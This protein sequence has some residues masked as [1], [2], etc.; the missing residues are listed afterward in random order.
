[1]VEL[2]GMKNYGSIAIGVNQYQFF[3]PLSFAQQDA[4]ALNNFLIELGGF[5]APKCQLLTESSPPNVYVAEGIGNRSTY[6]NRENI[7]QALLA[8]CEQLAAGD[9]FWFFFSGYGVSWQ[10][11]DYLMPIEGNPDDVGNT[12]I[13]TREILESLKAASGSDRA[14]V[15]LDVNRA[16]GT[17][18]NARI[19]PATE[20]IARQ[21]EI[22]TIFSCQH[23]QFSREVAGLERGFFTAALLEGLRQGCHTLEQ[24]DAHLR[25]RLPEISEQYFRP[26]QDPLLVIYPPAKIQGVLWPLEAPAD[27]NT[28]DTEHATDEAL[29]LPPRTLPKEA[30]VEG[31]PGRASVANLEELNGDK[32][33]NNSFSTATA[34]LGAKQRPPATTNGASLSP[35]APSPTVATDKDEAPTKREEKFSLA[36]VALIL[37]CGI[38]LAKLAAFIDQQPAQQQAST[39]ET[40]ADRMEKTSPLPGII[41][42]ANSINGAGDSEPGSRGDSETGRLGDGETGSRGDSETGRLGDSETG[43]NTATGQPSNTATG[44]PSNTATAQPSNTATAQPSNTVTAQPSN[45]ATGQPSNTATG[46]PSNT[47]TA[48]PSNTATGQPSN[49]ATGQPSN[50]ATGQPSNTATGQPSN[51][52]TGTASGSTQVNNATGNLPMAPLKSSQASAFVNAI[53]RSRQ[54]K[55]SDRLYPEAQQNIDR[56]SQVIL[57]I[58]YARAEE[59]NFGNAIAAAKMVPFDRAQLRAKAEQQIATWQPQYQL[60]QENTKL[61]KDA[62]ALIRPGVLTTYSQ[63]IAKVSDI[64]SGEPLHAQA[65]TATELWSQKIWEIAQYR[66]RRGRFPDAIAAAKLIP[67]DSSLYPEAQKAIVKWQPGN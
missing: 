61:L 58:A 18:G 46:Q 45:T 40:V 39:Q 55:P 22:P 29:P 3:Q 42:P 53:A 19:G 28:P 43:S 59:G 21:L 49:T 25:S 16:T 35:S 27:A 23:D 33:D 34:L 4:Q 8:G 65:R 47:A 15:I 5:A 30:L 20:A 2:A 60:Q 13:P 44:Q 64:T 11:E 48:Q 1:M 10:G 26:R 24:L 31:L 50:T 36:A 67:K 52:A 37:L 17:L 9:I 12:G 56:W 7:R 32:A 51:T 63:A 38:A 66:A 62:E 6:P 57:D 41:V 54:I 14:L